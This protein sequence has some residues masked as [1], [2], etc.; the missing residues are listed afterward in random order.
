MNPSMHPRVYTWLARQFP[1]KS[2]NGSVTSSD[3]ESIHYI[4]GMLKDERATAFLL[5]WP[6][7]EQRLFHGFVL[8]T[9]DK[10]KRKNSMWYFSI[11]HASIYS[12]LNEDTVAEYFHQRYQ[13]SNPEQYYY[14]LLH[15][16][17]R[18]AV[19]THFDDILE[20][21]FDNLTDQE[22]LYLM[23]FVT[24]R[25]RNNIFH[26]NKEITVWSQYK[27]QIVHCLTFM[28]SLIDAYH[29]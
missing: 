19:N 20:K 3:I 26:G 11:D 17:E 5:V 25:Y 15:K 8:D 18:P 24:Y 7:M 4:Q 10:R 27:R 2:A 29:Q 23:L 12:D 1:K 13:H 22:K 14:K 9:D 28:M 6:I 21:P 16:T